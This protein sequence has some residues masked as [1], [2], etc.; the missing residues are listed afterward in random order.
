MLRVRYA[1]SLQVVDAF[2]SACVFLCAYS[3]RALNLVGLVIA[4]AKQAYAMA[5]YFHADCLSHGTHRTP[6]R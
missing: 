5:G 1:A 2:V 4:E 3:A 6:L